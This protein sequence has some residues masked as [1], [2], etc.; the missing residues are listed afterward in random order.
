MAGAVLKKCDFGSCMLQNIF[1]L[2]RRSGIKLG[3][4]Q[5]TLLAETGTIEQV[6]SILTGSAV[7]VNIVEQREN[8]KKIYRESVILNNANRVLIRAH[9]KIFVCNLP[10]K[11]ARQIRQKQLGIGTI[12]ANSHLE[13][14]RKI[15]EVGYDP[16]NRSVFRRYQI[17]YRKK[18]A[19]DIREQLVGI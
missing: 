3:L 5:K 17:I 15:I 18:V 10:R 16:V 12:I 14:F 13:T 8:K 1:E 2:E 19:I 6:L 9:S 7:R 11:I 4:T